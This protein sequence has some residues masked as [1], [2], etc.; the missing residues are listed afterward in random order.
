MQK[1]LRPEFNVINLILRNIITDSDE[2]C[3]IQSHSVEFLWVH[4]AT[5]LDKLKNSMGMCM[6]WSKTVRKLK[7]NLFFHKRNAVS[8]LANSQDIKRIQINRNQFLVA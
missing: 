6:F 4:V 2:L 8:K 5:D 7:L 3:I 1:L